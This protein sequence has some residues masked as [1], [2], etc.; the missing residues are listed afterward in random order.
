MIIKMGY[1]NLYLIKANMPVVGKSKKFSNYQELCEI[2]ISEREKSHLIK[3]YYVVAKNQREAASLY[4]PYAAVDIHWNKNYFFENIECIE[5]CKGIEISSNWPRHNHRNEEFIYADELS[6]IGYNENKVVYQAIN[7]LSYKDI[8][9]YFM[10]IS[11]VIAVE[12]LVQSDSNGMIK[13]QNKI[14]IIPYNYSVLSF[15]LS[16]S[17]SFVDWMRKPMNQLSR[18]I[19]NN[20][21]EKAIETWSKG[22]MTPNCDES[23]SKCKE[24]CCSHIMSEYYNDNI[25][26]RQMCELFSFL[27]NS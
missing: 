18:T 26:L 12:F 15:S 8:R 17:P 11:Q 2:I 6:K 20:N 21:P 3:Q 14:L 4:I 19:Y 24:H 7:K 9:E 27:K 1:L 22:L 25:D 23:D 5:I 10:G 13:Y 16:S